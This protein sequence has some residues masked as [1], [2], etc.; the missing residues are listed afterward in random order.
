MISDIFSAGLLCIYLFYLFN[1]FCFL[2]I[3]FYFI[4]FI[5]LFIVFI[6][7]LNHG[8]HKALHREAYGEKKKKT[9][10]KL[11]KES[12]YSNSK[13]KKIEMA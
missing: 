4:C 12:M 2:F 6:Y 5:F 11:E 10:Q 13:N 3:L 1:L 9:Q 7:F 8:F